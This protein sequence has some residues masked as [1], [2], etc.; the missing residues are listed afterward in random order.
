MLF[1]AAGTKW[2]RIN[3]G[4]FLPCIDQWNVKK[5][6]VI[7]TTLDIAADVP[8]LSIRC[9]ADTRFPFLINLVLAHNRIETIEGLDNFWMPS[10]QYLD[11][12]T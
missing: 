5:G 12:C 9:I 7:G 10:L 2:H 8:V 4:D 1:E 11:I 3:L 6:L